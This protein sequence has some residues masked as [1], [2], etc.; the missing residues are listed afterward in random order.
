[1]SAQVEVAYQVDRDAERAVYAPMSR[2]RDG[3]L[4]D[5]DGKLVIDVGGGEGSLGA[6]FAVRGARV[7]L[8]DLDRESLR[9]S[10]G[11]TSA[12]R[13][14]ILDLPVKSEAADAVVGRAILHHVPDELEAAFAEMA[15]VLKPGG[16]LLIQEPCSGNWPA[17]VARRYVT[18]DRHEAGERV[19]PL[20][21]YVAA[22]RR[23]FTL[24][25]I[26]PHFLLSYLA[27]HVAS[28]APQGLAPWARQLT[29]WLASLDAS[30]LGTLPGLGDRAA[31]VSLVGR[32]AV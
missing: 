7:V 16:T 27:P 9:R 12:V 17:R 32:R 1:M 31:Y 5:A 29:R 14:S 3:F 22:M 21:T 6:T 10:R 30:L 28:R 23:H 15:R 4:P 2:I 18:T 11:V 24:D 26:E 13:G 20:R 19:L 25:R 8:V